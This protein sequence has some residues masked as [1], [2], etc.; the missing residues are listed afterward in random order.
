MRVVELVKLLSKLPC[1]CEV[2]ISSPEET[3]QVPVKVDIEQDHNTE[4]FFVRLYTEVPD[5]GTHG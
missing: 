2:I 4:K 3:V 1:D 5:G